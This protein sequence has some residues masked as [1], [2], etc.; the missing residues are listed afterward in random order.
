M[1]LHDNPTNMRYTALRRKTKRICLTA[2]LTASTLVTVMELISGFGGVV[3][4]QWW[5]LPAM[6]A[7]T[8]PIWLMMTAAT[9]L[10]N[11]AVNRRMALIQWL[12][13]LLS[14]GPI[15]H[16]CPLNVSFGNRDSGERLTVMTYNTFGFCDAEG[17]YPNHTNRTASQIINCGAD[18]V[19]LQEIGLISGS[20]VRELHDAQIDSINE[21]YP[22]YVYQEDKM[23]A[24]LSKYP[25]TEV[26]F[27][28]HDSPLSGVQGALVDFNGTEILVI[29]IHLQSIGLNEED[30][31]VYHNMTSRG[32]SVDWSNAGRQIYRKLANAF[33]KRS[34]QARMIRHQLDSLPYKSRII[35]G[36]FNDINDCYAM[37]TLAAGKMRN[38][39][40]DVGFGPTIT[41]NSNRFYFN[42]DHILYSGDLRADSIW[43]LKTRSSDHYPV[44]ATFTVESKKVV[45]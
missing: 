34:E 21:V 20:P 28:Q 30:K 24:V 6:V 11:I 26:D 35:A 14:A 25:L 2:W 39:F 44:F 41:Y 42:I 1:A 45:K 43:H 17:I 19:C 22:Y 23:L 16:I 15:V 10:I 27:Q 12:A 3:N 7:M 8:F 4:P 33:V 18:V 36:D 5:S 29:S 40:V 37:R 38:A 32:K 31:L 9:A 13:L